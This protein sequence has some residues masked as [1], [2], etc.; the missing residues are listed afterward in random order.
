MTSLELCKKTY[1]IIVNKH[2]SPRHI[3]W[4]QSNESHD[5]VLYHANADNNN[6]ILATAKKTPKKQGF[7][8]T[9]WKRDDSKTIRPYH[10]D[11]KEIDFF[12]VI[13]PHSGYFF[14]S[15]KDLLMNHILKSEKAK[16]KMAFRLYPPYEQLLSKEA[17]KT[18]KWQTNYYQ[19]L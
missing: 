9:L 3:F 5:Y 16:G 12:M 18:Q 8:V 15:K 7:F 1:E 4:Q 19:T 17:L 6:I 2:F 11:D 13:I 14:F 10:N